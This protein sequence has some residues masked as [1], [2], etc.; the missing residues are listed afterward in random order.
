MFPAERLRKV[1]EIMLEYKHIDISTLSSI[2]SVS[3][4]TIR[5][6]LAK[7]EQQGFLKKMHGGAILNEEDPSVKLAYIDDPFYEEKKS[8][9]KIASQVIKDGEIILLGNGSTCLEIARNIKDKKN[10]TVITNNFNVIEELAGI[11]NIHLV[12]TGGNAKVINES[13]EFV[14][15]FTLKV[16]EGIFINKSFISVQGIHL[17]HGYTVTRSEHLDF[18]NAVKSISNEVIVV[19][20]YSKFNKTALLPFCKID[21]ITKVITNENIPEKYKKYF[22]EKGIQLF[23]TVSSSD[24]NCEEGE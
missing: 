20:D 14:G 5:K 6:D 12:C 2:L 15:S 3:E 22:F 18:Y 10:L 9:A 7:L 16:L 23:T 13:I 19:A 21:D 11:D 1:K 4:V 8:I 24:I 17:Q